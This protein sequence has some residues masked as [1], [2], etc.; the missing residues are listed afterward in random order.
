MYKESHNSDPTSSA[1]IDMDDLIKLAKLIIAKI[2]GKN[3]NDLLTYLLANEYVV[4]ETLL[5]DTNIRSNEGRRI[6]QYLSDEA[7]VVPDKIRAS[8]G[9][10]L[11]AWRLNKS[12][13]IAFVLK[14]L[15]KAR[16]KLS[17]RMKFESEN[18]IYRCPQCRKIY[19]LEDA[20]VNDFYCPNDGSILVEVN[21]EE[22]LKVLSETINKL[23]YLIRKIEQ[24]YR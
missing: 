16:E 24:A 9:G 20:F 4:E 15:K 7:I 10:V 12:A 17:V 2:Y 23:D 21:K 22:R 5:Q 1:E 11:H 13:L 6:L 14:K 19:T 3:S 8:E 18:T